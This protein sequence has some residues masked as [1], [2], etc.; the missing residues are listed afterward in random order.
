MTVCCALNTQKF[1]PKIT[2][3]PAEKTFASAAVHEINFKSVTFLVNSS[4]RALQTCSTCYL[5]HS[6]LILQRTHARMHTHTIC[7][8]IHILPTHT[9]QLMLYLYV[10]AKTVSCCH[11]K[12]R[13][14]GHLSVNNEIFSLLSDGQIYAQRG[15]MDD[16]WSESYFTGM[17]GHHERSPES[18]MN[19]APRSH[20]SHRVV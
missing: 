10:S 5:L 9:L 17:G 15:K 20:R 18:K 4:V 19:E 11:Q 13:K 2:L 8:S 14:A 12:K 7:N 1:H 3:F 16:T 6:I